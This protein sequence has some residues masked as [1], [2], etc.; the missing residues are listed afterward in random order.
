MLRFELEKAIAISAAA[1]SIEDEGFIIDPI[2]DQ[3]YTGAEITPEIVVKDGDKVL[4]EG[5]DYEVSYEDNTETG[6]A[7]VIITGTGNYTGERTINFTIAPKDIA[8]ASVTVEPIGELVYTG[9]AL[10]PAV[11][12]RDGEKALVKDVD[13][14]VTYEN[15]TAAGTATVTITGTGNYTGETEATFEIA[16]KTSRRTRTSP[17]SPSPTRPIPARRLSRRSWSRTAARC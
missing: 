2:P 14:A 5:E 7:T 3:T 11:T 8:A 16:Q 17:S 15:N 6:T 12:V 9:S 1:K 4:V 13:Y 10:E